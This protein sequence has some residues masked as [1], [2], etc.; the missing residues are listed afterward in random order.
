MLSPK[1]GSLS[2]AVTLTSPLSDP[3]SLGKRLQV[4]SP[5]TASVSASASAQPPIFIFP[6]KSKNHIHSERVKM[7]TKTER[8]RPEN[9]GRE[10]QSLRETLIQ[11]KKSSAEPSDSFR[12]PPY[13]SIPAQHAFPPHKSQPKQ[14]THH[15][16][17]RTKH[18]KP[19]HLDSSTNRVPSP[20]NN[21]NLL[22]PEEDEE[23]KDIDKL[24]IDS[25]VDVDKTGYSIWAM[26]QQHMNDMASNIFSTQDTAFHSTIQHASLKS[27]HSVQ[28]KLHKINNLIHN[29]QFT[30][31]P[32]Y[33]TNKS[34]GDPNYQGNNH[35]KWGQAKKKGVRSVVL[36]N[37][38]LRDGEQFM[39]NFRK[40]SKNVMY[41]EE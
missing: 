24:S 25:E 40:R 3:E 7:Q 20:K 2:T 15:S 34:Y 6:Q 37:K 23:I 35:A 5:T 12:S 31:V 16:E 28:R 38:S 32:H 10:V 41:I 14:S 33:V 13:H 29:D 4:I 39:V 21:N 11:T 9:R 26:K 8:N 1:S 18:P 30:S 17:H 19:R 36:E 22:P 27:N